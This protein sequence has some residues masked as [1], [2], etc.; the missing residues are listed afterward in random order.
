MRMMWALT[1]N[2]TMGDNNVDIAM[3]NGEFSKKICM[4]VLGTTLRQK[5][6]VQHHFQPNNLRMKLA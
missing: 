5:H 2:L 3:D 4:R 1:A 6:S